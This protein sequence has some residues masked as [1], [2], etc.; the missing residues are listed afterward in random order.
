MGIIFNFSSK[1]EKEHIFAADCAC[2]DQGR[3]KLK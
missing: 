2:F 1:N 3:L